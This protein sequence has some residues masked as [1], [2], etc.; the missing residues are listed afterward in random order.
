MSEQLQLRRGNAAAIAAN[1]GALGEV[2]VDTDNK[3]LVLQDG[4]TNGGFPAAKLSEVITNTRTPISDAGYTALATDRLIAYTALTAARTVTLLAAS[5]YPTGTKLTRRR[6][7]GQ[8]LGDHTI[9]RRAR[10]LGHDQRRDVGGDRHGLRLSWRSNRTARATGRWSTSRPAARSGSARRRPPAARASPPTA[11]P[12][13]VT[14]ERGQRQQRRRHGDRHPAALR[15]H[16]I[17][18]R[19]G[20]GAQRGERVAHDRAGGRLHRERRRRASRSARPRRCPR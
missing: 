11:L 3:R 8:L 16:Q 12:F 15:R 1:A 5:A 10:R 18:R 13:V 19:A 6:R 17:P 7:I 14:A 4:S 2:F 9:T 20:D